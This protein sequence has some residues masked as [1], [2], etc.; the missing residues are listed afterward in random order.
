[1]AN[2]QPHFTAPTAK[3]LVVDDLPTNIRLVKEL[4][5][6]CGIKTYVSL[7]GAKAI[8]MIQ[9]ERYD[10]VFMDQEMPEMDGIK[11]IA[12]IRDMNGNDNYFCD[13]PIVMLTANETLETDEELAQKG[14][15]GY[16]TK[17][18]DTEKLFST[19]EKLLPADK[20]IRNQ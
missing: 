9:K 4:L 17:P 12:A 7:S 18:L 5:N 14:I 1:M 11:T 3:V 19:L 20:V 16:L 15:N 10:L 13:L 8:E 6:L 2:G